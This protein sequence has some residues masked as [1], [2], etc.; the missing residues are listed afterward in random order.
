MWYYMILAVSV[1]VQLVAVLVL[2][3]EPCPSICVQ[4]DQ[5]EL[6]ICQDGVNSE[7]VIHSYLQKG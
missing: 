5:W 7:P 3:Y 2:A 1:V 6:C 4:T